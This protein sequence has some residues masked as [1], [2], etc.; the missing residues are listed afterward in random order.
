MMMNPMSDHFGVGFG[1]E[2]VAQFLE[3]RAQR[4]VILDD[5]VVHDGDAAAGDMGVGIFRGR[6]AVGRPAGVGDTYVSRD[7]GCVERLLEN[8]HFDDGALAG[9]PSVFEHGDTGRIVA[10][11]LE[12][13]QALHE[14]GNRV[15]FRNHTYDATHI[16]LRR[17]I[18]RLPSVP[19]PDWMSKARPLTLVDTDSYYLLTTISMYIVLAYGG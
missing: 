8:V 12:A 6:N 13:P 14:D 3:A 11:V 15:A 10:A 19:D 16:V 7:R 18:K 4:F 9:D 5:P 17:P 1:S 2:G